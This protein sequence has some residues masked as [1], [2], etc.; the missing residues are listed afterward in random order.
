MEFKSFAL[1]FAILC[2]SLVHGFGF[3]RF[4]SFL[5]DLKGSLNDS[6]HE[7]H[8]DQD[9][10]TSKIS[11]IIEETSVDVDAPTSEATT[12]KIITATDKMVTT[13][14]NIIT[15]TPKIIRTKPKTVTTAAKDIT[16]TLKTITTTAEIIETTRKIVQKTARPATFPSTTQ[17]RALSLLREKLDKFVSVPMVP[18]AKFLTENEKLVM[19]SLIKAATLMDP[20]FER[21]VWTHNPRRVKELE[22]QDTPLSK[23]QLQ[24][25]AIMQGPWDRCNQ[26]K[27]FAIDREKPEGAGFYPE[28]MTEK[29]FKFYVGSNPAKK[30]TLESPVTLVKRQDQAAVYPVPLYGV[31]YS[32]AYEEWLKPASQHLREA[33]NATD[34]ESFKKFLN[35]R[36]DA[37]DSNDFSESDKDWLSVDSRVQI[38]I[39]PYRVEEDK[40]KVLKA[41]FEAIVYI[42]EQTFKPKFR[43]LLPE[44]ETEYAEL[45]PEL[46]ANLPVPEEV[47]NKSPRKTSIHVAELV[48]ASGNAKTYPQ[49][50]TFDYPTNETFR[51]ENGNRKIVLS[52][53]IYSF[54]ENIMTNIAK[55]IMKPK[56]LS[57]LDEDAFF[58]NVLYREL[59]HSLGPVFVGNDEAKGAIKE[60]F[61]PSHAP[62]EAAKAGVMGA[63]NLVKKV[64]REAISAD[65]TNKVLFTYIATLL[66]HVRDGSEHPEGKGSAIQLNS[67]LKDGSIVLLKE[68]NPDAGKYQVNFRKLEISMNKLVGDLVVLQHK[69]D[70]DA[71]N[72]M[73]EN[74]G[75]LDSNL[76]E[77]KESL[78][79]IPVDI[80]P[81]YKAAD[82]Y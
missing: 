16:T 35:S 75:T 70:K 61:G 21:Q 33:A 82:T 7:Q 6:L 22:D 13:T 73:I 28:D 69:G 80:R 63:Y 59:S 1:F 68:P 25:M 51:R 30:E 15:V 3:D 5:L 58:M 40:L 46:E 38:A 67:Y 66:Q 76:I 56:Q 48:F 10:A 43:T 18:D 57:F 74:F 49:Q 26:N 23:L 64:E 14:A 29:Q 37:F 77:V 81:T 44:T 52:N 19:I 11:K 17:S 62:L 31:P 54:Y 20:I 32:Q 36:S 65:F 39:G 34:N 60:V 41:S 78:E 71:A 8:K 12:A 72:K 42:S 2:P 45:I 50:F 4:E 47:K 27:P 55:R 79:D 24:Y 53:V 9:D